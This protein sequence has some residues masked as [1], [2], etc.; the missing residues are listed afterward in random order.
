LS[1]HE[2]NVPDRMRLAVLFKSWGP[3]HLA[4][5][6]ALR[7]KHDVLA[8]EN[9]DVD[10]VYDWKVEARKK[11]AKIVSIGA[12]DARRDRTRALGAQLVRF[13]PDAVAIPGYSEAFALAAARLCRMLGIPAILMSDTHA[14]SARDNRLREFA[15]RQL[16]TLFD[17]ALVAGAPHR[18]YLASLGFPRASI[19][20][21]Y[22]VVDNSHFA[23]PAWPAASPLRTR[24]PYFFCCARLVPKKNIA[25]L[26]D[27]FARY[28]DT[29]RSHTWNL[30]IAGDGPLRDVLEA[31]AAATPCRHA[32]H[33]LG[34][35]GYDDLPP[36][37]RAAGAFVLPSRSEEWGLVVNEAMAAALPVLVSNRAGCARDLVSEGVNGITF[38]PLD[39]D[40]L[41]AAITRISR[42]GDANLAG[43]GQA[44]ARLI[45]G[46]N[47][48]RF[49]TGL[50]QAAEAALS[51]RTRHTPL[52]TKALTAA[53]A[54]GR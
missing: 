5:L 51:A 27:A 31:Q 2:E 33:F 44:S 49:A 32:I 8:L 47:A 45:A 29:S 26:I 54:Y 7:A 10:E 46:W 23:R 11:H 18:D 35:L 19:A 25:F 3:Y 24:D 4:R 15:K 48:D 12:R 37:Y 42:A 13:A 14:L 39:R 41:A 16:L 38:D 36:V 28:R 52:M 50:T 9:T 17:A 1:A 30:V 40:A 53:L 6:E 20:L 34:K 43:M 22:D 21:G